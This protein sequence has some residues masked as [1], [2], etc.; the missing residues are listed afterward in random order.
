MTY[1]AEGAGQTKMVGGGFG[2]WRQIG[3]AVMRLHCIQITEEIAQ[4]SEL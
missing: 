4:S 1:I 2:V 3:F